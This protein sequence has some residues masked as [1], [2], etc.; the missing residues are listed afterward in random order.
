MNGNIGV[1]FQA[2]KL[3]LDSK[4]N[5]WNQKKLKEYSNGWPL[6]KKKKLVYFLDLWYLRYIKEIRFSNNRKL[7]FICKTY[8]G[9]YN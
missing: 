6:S 8:I 4:D 2:I 9:N 7:I 5:N 1:E 3:K